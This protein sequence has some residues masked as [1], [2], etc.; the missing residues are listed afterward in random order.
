MSDHYDHVGS[1]RSCAI[2]TIMDHYDHYG[3][4]SSCQCVIKQYCVSVAFPPSSR[5]P[6]TEPAH[7]HVLLRHGRLEPSSL[8]SLLHSSCN[9][10]LLQG[11]VIPPRPPLP[12][13]PCPGSTLFRVLKI[14]FPQ[15][16]PIFVLQ[17]PDFNFLIFSPCEKSEKRHPKTTTYHFTFTD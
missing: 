3:A 2:I 11:L 4:I 12:S 14:S 1:L 17:T 7:T 13:P 16:R 10:S 8:F 15:N 5:F 9:L 6:S